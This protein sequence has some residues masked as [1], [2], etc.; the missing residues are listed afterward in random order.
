MLVQTPFRK[1]CECET[2]TRMR[3]NFFNVSSNQ[4]QASKSAVSRNSLSQVIRWIWQ[5]STQSRIRLISDFNHSI[6]LQWG[7][8]ANFFTWQWINY[9][10]VVPYVRKIAQQSKT[11]YETHDLQF[12]VAN[13]ESSFDNNEIFETLRT[14]YNKNSKWRFWFK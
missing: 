10:L 13:G 12:K 5:F 4:T 9:I 6:Q 14:F 11:F 3:S 1:S 8:V 2:T 7:I